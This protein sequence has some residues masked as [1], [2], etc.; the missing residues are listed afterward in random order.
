MSGTV[1]DLTSRIIARAEKQLARD[2]PRIVPLVEHG[3]RAFAARD[4]VVPSDA[5]LFITMDAPCSAQAQGPIA[6]VFTRKQAAGILRSRRGPGHRA[7]MDTLINQRAPS[8]WSMHVVL[9]VEGSTVVRRRSRVPVVRL[10]HFF[11]EWPLEYRNI[12]YDTIIRDA[13][14]D[15]VADRMAK[16]RGQ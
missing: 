4:G 9:M 15:E 11:V 3:L 6:S 14:G 1:I 8:T 10:A 7:I 12:L 16:R 5:C 2:L 13:C